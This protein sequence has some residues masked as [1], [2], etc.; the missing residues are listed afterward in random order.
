M[1]MQSPKSLGNS[2][3]QFNPDGI[4]LSWLKNP[5]P[6]IKVPDFTIQVDRATRPTYPKWFEGLI[7]PELEQTGPIQYDLRRDVQPWLHDQQ[8]KKSEAVKG[9]LVYKHLKRTGALTSCLNLQDGLAIMQKGVD[10]FRSLFKGK[11]PPLWGSVV[12]RSPGELRVPCLF[13]HDV[14]IVI[15]WVSLAFSLSIDEPTLFHYGN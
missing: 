9:Y 8:K 10:V 7:N 4:N 5:S 2:V 3:G 6:S 14:A 13:D 1:L 11:T 15:M 12:Q